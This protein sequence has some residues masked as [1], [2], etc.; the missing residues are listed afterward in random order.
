MIWHNNLDPFI[1]G[2]WLVRGQELGIRW[3]SLP[4]IICFISIYAA[5][6]RAVHA[7]R[8]PNADSDR[9]EEGA[10]LLILSI[11]VGGRL[12]YFVLNHPAS[13]LTWQGWAEVPKVWHGGMAF[14]GA[15]FTVFVSEYFYCRRH[16]LGF[17]HASDRIMWIFALALGF[18][19]VANFINSELVGIP[20]SGGWGVIFD[21]LPPSEWINGV[22]VPR[23][24]VQ[25]YSA[26]THWALGLWLLYL[27]RR[28]P[29][30]LFDR[31]PGF[32]C[33]WF[34]GGYGLMRIL[35]D[36]FREESIWIIPGVFN[37]GQALSLA[38]MLAAMAGARLRVKLLTRH[39]QEHDWY[40]E[41][42]VTA[43]LPEVCHAYLD[44]L[45][46]E[47]P[48]PTPTKERR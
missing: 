2:P 9:L 21:R 6:H 12:G 4:Y 18:G 40:P 5:L 7:R 8:I 29:R 43:P 27:L 11:I 25:L 13:L 41:G 17:W 20:T 48:E 35:S 38:M 36:F 47:A 45:P 28:R 3:Y 44:G 32:T 26:L 19:R 14:F 10:L 39:G 1:L 33:F 30:T 37:G 42:G 24:P 15:A 22:N 46:K 34:L 16:K 31:V 23:H